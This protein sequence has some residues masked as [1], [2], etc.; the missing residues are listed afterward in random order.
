VTTINQN[1]RQ[2]LAGDELWIEAFANATD[3]CLNNKNKK[4]A[5]RLKKMT[6]KFKDKPNHCNPVP[7]QLIQCTHNMVFV[8]CP[9]V[10][11]NSSKSLMGLTRDIGDFSTSFSGEECVALH[12]EQDKRGKGNRGQKKEKK[13]SKQEMEEGNVETTTEEEIRGTTMGTTPIV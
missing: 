11:R 5:E 1:F 4:I 12:S 6:K 13:K 3:T 7:N 10:A 2:N 9:V 8:N